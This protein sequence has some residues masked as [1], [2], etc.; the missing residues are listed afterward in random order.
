MGGIGHHPMTHHVDQH[1]TMVSKF[2]KKSSHP[3]VHNDLCYAMQTDLENRPLLCCINV[4]VSV[5][6][7][8]NKDND[9]I[10]RSEKIS[11]ELE[12][13]KVLPVNHPHC[14]HVSLLHTLLP[15][16]KHRQRHNGPR[17]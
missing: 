11:Q 2:L 17:N 6:S 7:G 5:P 15:E 14:C 10:T 8:Q 3:S 13:F 16:I 12:K 1:M 4:H 9:K